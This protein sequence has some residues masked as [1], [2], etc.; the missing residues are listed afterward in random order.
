MNCRNPEA[1]DDDAYWIDHQTQSRHQ[2]ASLYPHNTYHGATQVHHRTPLSQADFKPIRFTDLP[3]AG[4]GYVQ[5][6]GKM[7][8]TT[9]HQ[10]PTTNHP[11]DFTANTR[12]ASNES[13]SEEEVKSD[14]ILLLN[15]NAY[16][17]IV[18]MV[19]FDFV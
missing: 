8:T 13:N 14:S 17:A 1:D 18:F 15:I 12:R 5:M 4:P 10:M 3:E 7:N 16:T 2:Q 9:E 6:T 19:K 11:E